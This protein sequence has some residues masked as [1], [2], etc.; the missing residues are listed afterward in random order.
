MKTTLALLILF[1]AIVFPALGELTDADLNKIRLIV[2][3]EIKVV[4][5]EMKV[6]IATINAKIDKETTTIN[7]KIDAMDTRLRTV[8]TSVAELR[9]RKMGI[10]S[11]IKTWTLA[12]CAVA[13]LAISIIALVETQ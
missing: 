4:R 9:G 3:E 13:A 12:I 8:E 6:E 1:S 2:Q 10:S 11:A 5:E 7:A